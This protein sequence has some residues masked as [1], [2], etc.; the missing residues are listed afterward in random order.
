M[1]V[2]V[3]LEATSTTISVFLAT[4]RDTPHV[5]AEWH[6]EVLGTAIGLVAIPSDF[7]SAGQ[8]RP[9]ETEA[10]RMT[11][12][13]S[14]VARGLTIVILMISGARIGLKNVTQQEVGATCIGVLRTLRLS[15]VPQVRGTR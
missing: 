4:L 13:R 5:R 2:V 10:D 14:V 3:V 6:C 15:L 8:P 1:L 12:L 7:C 9:A 11:L